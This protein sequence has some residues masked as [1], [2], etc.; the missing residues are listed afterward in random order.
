MLMSTIQPFTQFEIIDCENS[1]THLLSYAQQKLKDASLPLKV[2]AFS[3]LRI[4]CLAMK[5]SPKSDRPWSAG[6][7][8]LDLLTTLNEQDFEWWNW[9]QVTD[10]GVLRS[11]H[12]EIDRLLSPF[13]LFVTHHHRQHQPVHYQI[14]T[15]PVSRQFIAPTEVAIAP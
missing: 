4:C 8:Y 7:A 11:D 14:Y 12:L 2:R 10:V 3:Y 5:K 13:A 15:I 9:C 1:M 6:Q